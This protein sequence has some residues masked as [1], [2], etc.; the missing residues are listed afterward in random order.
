MSLLTNSTNI[1]YSKLLIMS[2]NKF[3]CKFGGNAKIYQ[4]YFEVHKIFM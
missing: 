4:F 2:P 1:I 3:I